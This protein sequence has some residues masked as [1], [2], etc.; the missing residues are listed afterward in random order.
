M[1]FSL[2]REGALIA[3]VYIHNSRTK[4]LE[5]AKKYEDLEDKP[6][7]SP[8]SVPES[9]SEPV[10]HKPSAR[11]LNNRALAMPKVLEQQDEDTTTVPTEPN[12][13]DRS[14]SRLR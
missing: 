4:L 9:P 3:A 8:H 13:H 5:E 10:L 6:V 7:K 12:H 1:E 14:S 2:G 11:E